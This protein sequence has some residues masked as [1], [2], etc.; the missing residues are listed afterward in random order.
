MLCLGG[1]LWTG[2]QRVCNAATLGTLLRKTGNG[3]S[4]SPI[5]MPGSKAR[6]AAMVEKKD[7]DVPFVFPLWHLG[8][9]IISSNAHEGG[10][11]D[12]VIQAMPHGMASARRRMREQRRRER[13]Q[14]EHAGEMGKL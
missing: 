10:A 6:C 13:K 3:T 11:P 9:R 1:C 12:Y 7:S 4:L 5:S 14:M 8:R 2:A